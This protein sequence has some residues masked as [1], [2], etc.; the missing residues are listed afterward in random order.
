[1]PTRLIDYSNQDIIIHRFWICKWSII[2]LL[3]DV[4]AVAIHM[5]V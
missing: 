1:M 2:N 4:F 5:S 3:R